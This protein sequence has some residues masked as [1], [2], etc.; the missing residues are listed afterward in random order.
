MLL[1]SFIKEACV[2]LEKLYPSEEA[3]GIVFMLCHERLG[4]ENYTHIIEPSTEISPSLLPS[5]YTDLARLEKAEPVQYVLGWA[6]FA[7]RRYKVGPGVL[8]PRPETEQLVEEALS[9]AADLK[10]PARILD[11]CCGSGCITWSLALAGHELVGV[12][13]SEE[14]LAYARGQF[15]GANASFVKAD[16]LAGPSSFTSGKFD[17]IVS[18]PPYI[19]NKEKTLMRPNVLNFEPSLALFVED[20]DPLVFYRAVAAWSRELLAEGGTG[21]V[22]INEQL[23]SETERVFKSAGFGRTAVVP[24]IFGKPRFVKFG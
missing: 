7:G 5:L 10:R 17:I 19:M 24:D 20:D 8:I 1:S 3:R 21:I 13:I 22:E 12:D 15:S 6:E 9:V 18:N 11:L 2:A 4:V 16:V 14:A 23:P